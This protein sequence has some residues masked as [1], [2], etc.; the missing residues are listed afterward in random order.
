[1]DT[2]TC[3]ECGY[4]S[5][6]QVHLSRISLDTNTTWYPYIFSSLYFLGFVVFRSWHKQF[7]ALCE[8]TAK[9][10]VVNRIPSDNLLVGYVLHVSATFLIP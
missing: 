2:G 3:V 6:R 4:V 8:T 1:M 7:L 9:L 5:K 10:V